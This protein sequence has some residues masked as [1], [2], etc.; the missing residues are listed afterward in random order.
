MFVFILILSVAA[1]YFSNYIMP[2][3]NLKCRTIIYNIQQKKPTFGITEGLF[4]NDIDNYSI[5]V[6]EKN[7]KT[8]ELIDILIYEAGINGAG[9]TILAEL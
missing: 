4:Y 5:K 9:K 7:D 6:E 1:F 8:G 2:I 3:A